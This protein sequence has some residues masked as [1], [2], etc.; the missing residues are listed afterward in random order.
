MA[1]C[2]R[3]VIQIIYYALYVPYAE[4]LLE[5]KSRSNFQRLRFRHMTANSQSTVDSKK[6]SQLSGQAGQEDKL[7]Y[8]LSLI[9]NVGQFPRDVA[10]KGQRGPQA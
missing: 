8:C 1:P 4:S 9:P 10:T 6:N 2:C 5:F 7:N 3:L